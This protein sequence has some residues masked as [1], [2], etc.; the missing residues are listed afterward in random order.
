[1]VIKDLKELQKVIQ[2]CRKLGVQS[3]E[4]DNVKL[5]LGSL[6]TKPIKINKTQDLGAFPEADVK[7]PQY[8]GQNLVDSVTENSPPDKIETDELTE[9][10]LMFYSAQSIADDKTYGQGQ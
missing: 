4:I 10:Q 8:N 3:I 1:M 5:Q 7:V 6:P 9:E 2:T